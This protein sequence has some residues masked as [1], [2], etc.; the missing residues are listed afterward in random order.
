ME[1]GGK[2]LIY[3]PQRMVGWVS[4]PWCLL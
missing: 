2:Y 3:L 1:D 4:W